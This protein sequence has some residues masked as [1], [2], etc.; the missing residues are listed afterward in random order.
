MGLDMYLSAKRSLY[1]FD[2]EVAEIKAKIDG[3]MNT[4]L[5]SVQEVAINVGYW[6]K[7]NA[8]HKWFVDNV[9][10]GVDECQESYLERDDLEKL[11]IAVNQ[12]LDNPELAGEVLPPSDGFFFGST[13]LDEWYF[14]DLQETK[15]LLERILGAPD[16]EKWY[17]YYRASW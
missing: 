3:A 4:S 6:R 7:A 13:D 5:G 12:A 10:E 15:V 8:I 9:Q 2:P 1:D 14:R 16:F 17:F 11:L